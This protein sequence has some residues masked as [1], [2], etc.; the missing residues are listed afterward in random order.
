MGISMDCKMTMEELEEEKHSVV[1]QS[2]V[3]E[4]QSKQKQPFWVRLQVTIGVLGIGKSL[5]LEALEISMKLLV[6]KFVKDQAYSDIQQTAPSSTSVTG[7]S[8]LKNLPCTSSPALL[9]WL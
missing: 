6:Q 9:Q 4:D 2:R 3:L 8:G 5:V 1:V 7:T